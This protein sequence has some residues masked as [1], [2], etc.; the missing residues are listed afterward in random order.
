MSIISSHVFF[1]A[2]IYLTQFGK[3]SADELQESQRKM[4]L[5]PDR[6]RLR[7]PPCTADGKGVGAESSN[8]NDDENDDV[9]AWPI[10]QCENVFVLPGVPQFFEEKLDVICDHFLE[11]AGRAIYS[12]KVGVG[13]GYVGGVWN[14]NSENDFMFP[15]IAISLILFCSTRILRT[16]RQTWYLLKIQFMTHLYSRVCF[17][18]CSG[19]FVPGRVAFRCTSGNGGRCLP[20]CCHWLLPLLQPP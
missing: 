17:H 20:Q 6:A 8:Q 10:L 1:C 18:P 5:L 19:V 4:A 15:S 16:R 9:N 7:F 13:I 11:G 3:S 12:V 14:A 2:Y